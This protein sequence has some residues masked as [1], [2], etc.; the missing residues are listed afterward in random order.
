MSPG[1][2]DIG[3]SFQRFMGGE[4]LAGYYRQIN[5]LHQQQRDTGQ[6]VYVPTVAPDGLRAG[7]GRGHAQPGGL[8]LLPA[9]RRRV[10]PTWSKQMTA[11][12]LEAYFAYNGVSAALLAPT[13]LL[14]V[15]GTQDSFLLPE[16]GQADYD[17]A[18]GPK[19]LTW[20]D[21]H[22][23]L[24]LYDQDPYVTQAVT[25]VADFFASHLPAPTTA[26]SS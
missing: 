23:H 21:T 17:G 1:G 26:A 5:E 13:P 14:I 2:F 9:H 6:T 15:H 22:H 3:G 24:E 18:T 10:R 7:P 16:C 4:G 20:I 19:Q 11:A 12:G 25:A 8:R